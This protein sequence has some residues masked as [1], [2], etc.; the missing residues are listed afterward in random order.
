MDLLKGRLGRTFFILLASAIGST[1]VTAIYSTVDMVCIGQYAGAVGSAAVACLN[2]LWGIMMAPGVMIGVGGAIMTA[3]RRGAGDPDEADG[4]F[5]VGAVVTTVIAL[6]IG[7]VYL[8]FPRQLLAF[9]GGEGAV[10]ESAVDYMSS[11]SFV[12]PTFTIS[13][14][15]SYYIRGDG[16]ALVPTVATI[17]G[18]VVNAVLDVL[19]VFDFG[20]GMG[21]KG[22]GLATSIGQMVAFLGLLSYFLF[23]RCKL[24]LA[25][26]R[27]PL[28]KLYR[29]ASVGF[30]AF[31]VE[32]SFGV[33]VA[34]FNRL[35]TEGLS[36][37]HLAVYGTASTL[38]ALLVCIFNGVGVALQPLASTA[39]GAGDM[40]RVRST[41][42]LG[43][44]CS[45]I[46]GVVFCIGVLCAPTLILAFY[47]DVDEGVLAVGPDIM[48]IYCLGLFVAGVNVLAT[49]YFQAVLKRGMSVAVSLLR[50]L[51]L[52][53]ALAGAL[54]FGAG[55]DAIWWSL[56]LSELITFA[57]SLVFLFT[58][59]LGRDKLKV[60]IEGENY[61]I[62]A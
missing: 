44:I 3:N 17:A 61:G 41:L 52:P 42:R 9:F 55:A 38:F 48:R 26:V 25:R 32:I 5:T 62:K 58:A 18:G 37:S 47:M 30:S 20:A 23:K 29:I 46:L 43:L 12:A 34:V 56:P 19:L 28:A 59:S 39:F 8:I 21:V 35:I 40:G 2:P 60:K 54:Y 7:A 45:V 1:V 53:V 10:L 14:F 49:Y 33:T 15:L 4:Y 22:A 31:I 51:V 27:A 16:E 11:I 50:T 13:C 24:R 36:E 6:L 57:V